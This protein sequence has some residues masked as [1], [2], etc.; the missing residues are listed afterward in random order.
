MSKTSEKL[1]AVAA[2]LAEAPVGAVV[3]D[4]D[5][6]R[7]LADCANGGWRAGWD[8][9]QEDVMG[10]MTTAEVLSPLTVV[11]WPAGEGV[12]GE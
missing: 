9:A 2:V 3:L 11:E 7:W 10:H 8:G 5:G 1:D 6:D 4:K 12:G